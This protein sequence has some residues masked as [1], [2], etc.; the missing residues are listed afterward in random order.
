MNKEEKWKRRTKKHDSA[1]EINSD[2]HYCSSSSSSN[3]KNTN[4]SKII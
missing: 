2:D 3:C 1:T 4:L